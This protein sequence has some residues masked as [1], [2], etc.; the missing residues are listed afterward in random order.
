MRQ[1]FIFQ[2]CDMTSGDGT[3]IDV[4][5]TSPP[6]DSTDSLGWAQGR[7]N[8]MRL[9]WKDVKDKWRLPQ[10]MVFRVVTLTL[11]LAEEPH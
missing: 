1:T 8:Q 11:A 5:A 4:E 10:E 3:W 7:V 6:S 9:H 2:R